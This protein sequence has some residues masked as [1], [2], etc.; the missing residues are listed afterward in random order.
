MLILKY[1]S[2]RR[3]FHLKINRI[4]LGCK[5]DKPVINEVSLDYTLIL[6][7]SPVTFLV[8][9]KRQSFKGC[10]A[11]IY[12]SGSP[13]T[14]SPSGNTPLRYDMINFKPSSS[15][16]SYISAMDIPLDTP[17][18]LADDY[19]V[20]SAIRSMKSHSIGRSRY[21]SEFAELAMRLV[22]IAVSDSFGEL[23][24]SPN[25]TIPHYAKLKALRDSIYDNPLEFRTSEDMSAELGISRTYFHRL[26]LEAFS[27]TCHQDIIEARIMYAAKLLETTDISISMIAEQCGYES[28]SYFMRQF[29]KHKGCTP[30]EYRRRCSE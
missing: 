30:T 19:I 25:E 3:G 29:R 4:S 22:F 26:Y 5:A 17:V 10:C 6:F 20:T 21:S 16:R 15:E 28:D 13:R 7:R 1:D 12:T 2:K 11:V 23:Q 8:N 14:F 24:P 18:L 9:G 27:V